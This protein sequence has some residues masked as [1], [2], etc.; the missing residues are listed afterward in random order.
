[1]SLAK[2]FSGQ[3]YLYIG[4]G[5]KYQNK[6]CSKGKSYPRSDKNPGGPWISI[7]LLSRIFWPSRLFF[8]EKKING[9]LCESKVG[10]GQKSRTRCQRY[11]RC[12][13]YTSWSQLSRFSNFMLG[14]S[15]W[16][17]EVE[18]EIEVAVAAS[19]EDLNS[20]LEDKEGGTEDAPVCRHK[21]MSAECWDSSPAKS[22]KSSCK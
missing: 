21:A 15:N 1:M 3:S 19:E 17:S 7:H 6:N 5:K 13:T 2:S 22:R 20:S 16:V 18:E 10:G 9:P 11:W 8:K 4:G 14:L 12:T